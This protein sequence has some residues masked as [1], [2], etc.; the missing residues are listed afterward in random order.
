VSELA[1]YPRRY[2]PACDQL[3]DGFEP[4]PAGRANSKCPRCGA[5]E[6][7]RFLALLLDTLRPALGPLQ[8]VLDVAPVPAVTKVVQR[9]EPASYVRV[10]IGYDNRLVDVIGSVTDLPMGDDSVHLAICFHVL[11]H[12]PDHFKAMRELGRVLAPGGL[13]VIQVPWRP[14]RPTEEDLGADQAERLRRFGQHDHVR[15][16]GN[17][18]EAMLAEQGLA[19]TRVNARAYFGASACTWMGLVPQSNLWILRSTGAGSLPADV[20][21]VS[22]RL[23]LALDALVG[24]LAKERADADQA[25]ERVGRLRARVDL[26]RQAN[27]RLRESAGPPPAPLVVRA[28][29]RGGRLARRTLGR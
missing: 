11:E 1:D 19:V 15:Y 14:D 12:V 29:R 4:G 10:D 20:E 3:I 27:K 25:R 7:H 23:T 21:P 24:Q 28:A 9:L 5:L 6:R 8:T 16:Y 2:C 18:F 22:T 13:A 26:L 17:D